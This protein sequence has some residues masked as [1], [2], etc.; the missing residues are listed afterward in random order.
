[1][2]FQDHYDTPTVNSEGL[3]SVPIIQ[4]ETVDDVTISA[5]GHGS[6]FFHPGDDV[7]AASDVVKTL[8]AE[9]HTPDRIR[10]W[11]QRQSD[12]KAESALN[13]ENRVAR[14]EREGA[15]AE[16]IAKAKTAR[17]NSAATAAAAIAAV[18]K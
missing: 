18:G 5:K 3:I 10:A 11:A 8:A 17:D 2:A 13:D 16:I 7:S 14:L 6:L 4:V 1:M 12:Q 15:D 9:H